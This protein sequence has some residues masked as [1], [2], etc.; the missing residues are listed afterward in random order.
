MQRLITILTMTFGLALTGCYQSGSE[1]S[2]PP[3]VA[4]PLSGVIADGQIY[5]E[6]NCASCHNIGTAYAPP[7]LSA[8]DMKGRQDWIQSDMSAADTVSGFNLMSSFSNIPAQRVAD[9]KAFVA[10]KS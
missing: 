3:P 6:S 7:H 5:Y 1:S 10:S 8:L 2:P 4:K 9:L